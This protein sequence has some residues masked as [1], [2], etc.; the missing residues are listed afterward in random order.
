M[1]AKEDFLPPEKEIVLF[2]EFTNFAGE[3]KKLVRIITNREIEGFEE[4]CIP[5]F[6]IRD[7][8]ITIKNIMEDCNCHGTFPILLNHPISEEQIVRY[9]D[10]CRDQKYDQ[11]KFDHPAYAMLADYME[12]ELFLEE[13]GEY[14]RPKLWNDE[15]IFLYHHIFWAYVYLP[16]INETFYLDI[17]EENKEI[18]RYLRKYEYEKIDHSDL[19]WILD[20][21]FDNPIEVWGG[22][23]WSTRSTKVRHVSRAKSFSHKK[24]LYRFLTFNPLIAKKVLKDDPCVLI[25]DTNLAVKFRKRVMTMEYDKLLEVIEK[26]LVEKVP[27]I[28][29][30]LSEKDKRLLGNIGGTTMKPGEYNTLVKAADSRDSLM[31]RMEEVHS[32][33]GIE[34][35]PKNPFRGRLNLFEEANDAQ[36]NLLAKN[37]Q[38]QQSTNQKKKNRRRR[39]EE[40]N[41]CYQAPGKTK[42]KGEIIL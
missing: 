37:Y 8:W 39:K 14:S 21:D 28:I 42:R 19:R 5:R 20:I 12:D 40:A 10:Y 18:V 25:C 1:A 6:V 30:S 3:R 26:D 29:I 33:L 27:D 2:F 17:P 41:Q 35:K 13:F 7:H 22:E 38:Q 24:C 34:C 16:Y 32:R 23:V 31:T 36:I 15:E 4:F 9:I 11:E